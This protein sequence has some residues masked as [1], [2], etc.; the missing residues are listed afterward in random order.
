[1]MLLLWGVDA[2][3]NGVC[4]RARCVCAS[5]FFH[6]R[7]FKLLAVLQFCLCYS[8]MIHAYH[9]SS[10]NVLCMSRKKT[11]AKGTLQAAKPRGDGEA[12]HHVDQKL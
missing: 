7:S 3:L 2:A 5:E 11:H 10:T 9:C 12:N 8:C 1:M 4:L 6:P